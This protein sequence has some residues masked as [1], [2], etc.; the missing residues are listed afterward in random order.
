MDFLRDK[1]FK[2][3]MDQFNNKIVRRDIQHAT[4][5]R[6]IVHSITDDSDLDRRIASSASKMENMDRQIKTYEEL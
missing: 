1:L 3:T 2:A 5:S 6:R 4:Y